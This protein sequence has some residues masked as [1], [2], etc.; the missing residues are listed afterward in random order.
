MKNPK[1]LTLLSL[2]SFIG[3]GIAVYQTWHFFQ[4]R[5]GLAGFRSFCT[6]GA[7][8]CQ[9]IDASPYAQLL[10]GFPLAAFAAGW[11]L[12]LTVISILARDPRKR[13]EA[14]K[15]SVAMA[16][17]GLAFSAFYLFIMVAVLKTYCLLCLIVDVINVLIFGLIMSLLPGNIKKDGGPSSWKPFAAIAAGGVG[18]AFILSLIL[19]SDGPSQTQIQEIVMDT[20]SAPILPVETPDRLPSIGPKDAPITLVKF[21][22]FQCP[23]CKRGAHSIHPLMKTHAGKIRFVFRNYPL[24]PQCNREVK[25][26]VHPAACQAAKLAWCMHQK[27]KFTE[28]YEALFE[29]QEMLATGDMLELVTHDENE[30]AS[31]RACIDSKEAMEAISA[32]VE[33]GIRLK[34]RSTPTFFL[35][36]RR[37]EGSLPPTI[38]GKIIDEL[39]KDKK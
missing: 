9:A 17:A 38:W 10:P 12:A 16:G 6:F 11:L 15:A 5:N 30:K 37:I 3:F 7:F 25:H 20:V 13:R 21:S 24:D 32:D 8:D 22:D 36:G 28:A 1:R 4:I 27:G 29:N 39:L 23:A 31:L 33:E 19:G 14:L 18:F 35:N 34:V 26:P 2:L